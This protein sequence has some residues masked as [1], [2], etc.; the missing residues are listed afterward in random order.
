MEDGRDPN[1]SLEV[2]RKNSFL[3][4]R[5]KTETA[6]LE[7]NS[8]TNHHDRDLLVIDKKQWGESRACQL[9]RV[10][11]LRRFSHP[12]AKWIRFDT[13]TT[14]NQIS[15]T[16]SFD[17]RSSANLRTLPALSRRIPGADSSVFYTP[18]PIGTY[19]GWEQR[20]QV[21]TENDGLFVGV[22]EPIST[23]LR[24]REETVR[25]TEL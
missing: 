9:L 19:K 21:W 20:E 7:F 16:S 17:R 15:P 22:L 3:G 23:G 1:A 5:S 12:P 13:E 24:K 2:E 8:R 6:L 4:Q 14:V 11:I 18:E 10:P 25:T